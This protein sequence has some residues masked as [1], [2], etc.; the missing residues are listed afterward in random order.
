MLSWEIIAGGSD[1]GATG[2]RYFS[3]T[4]VRART[5]YLR[6]RR[7]QGDSGP[8]G[9]DNLAEGVQRAP[10]GFQ[11]SFQGHPSG[12]YGRKCKRANGLNVRLRASTLK[13]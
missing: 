12:V 2:D 10:N 5:A 1:R 3:G 11:L 7:I 8:L 4:H 6:P 13:R 9:V